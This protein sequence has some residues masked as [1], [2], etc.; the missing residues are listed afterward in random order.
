MN[1]TYDF[2]PLILAVVFA[3]LVIGIIRKTKAFFAGRKGAPL[4]QAYR[5]LFKMLKKGSVYSSST[6]WIFR[7]APLISLAVML[8]AVAWMPFGGHA[9]LFLFEGD[10]LVIIYLLA[11]SRFFTFLAAMDTASSF[12]GMGVSREGFFSILA[13][14]AILLGLGALIVRPE[15]TS[16][17]NIIHTVALDSS[18]E[19]GVLVLLVSI[20]FVILTAAENGRI[21]VDDPTTHLELTMLHEVMIL[22]NSGP[23]LAMIEYAVDLKLWFFFSLIS[24]LILPIFDYG[25][26][27]H[28]LLSLVSVFVLA[29]I[30]GIIESS[31]ARLRLTRIPQLLAVALA[32]SLIA[33]LF[34]EIA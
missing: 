6:T 1:I 33:I 9:G 26:L 29:G 27:V 4:L 20:S 16:F 14:P 11:F 23:D 30:M 31:M 32:M 21:P 5:D 28:T 24:N 10:F 25:L 19:F 15:H 12:E 34:K 17:W 7:A 22:D 8:I 2:I 13:E 3:P 18:F